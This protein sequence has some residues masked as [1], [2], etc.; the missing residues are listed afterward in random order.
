VHEESANGGASRRLAGGEQRSVLTSGMGKIVTG[1]GSFGRF[2]PSYR[3]RRERGVCPGPAH[4]R[5]PANR[6]PEWVDHGMSGALLW[7]ADQWA[8]VSVLKGGTSLVRT[9]AALF[10]GPAY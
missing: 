8:S 10:M 2:L 5:Q 9:R 7:V 6:S 3:W 4:R 1:K